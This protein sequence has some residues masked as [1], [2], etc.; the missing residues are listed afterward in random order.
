VKCALLGKD[1]SAERLGHV[2]DFLIAHGEEKEG[3]RRDAVLKVVK[4]A[5][6]GHGPARLLVLWDDKSRVAGTC[7]FNVCH[8]LTGPYV[9]VTELDVEP[10]GEIAALARQ[11]VAWT[12]EQG[13]AYIASAVDPAD[14]AM[15]KAAKSQG[16]E[17]RPAFWLELHVQDDG[18]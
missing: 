6:A 17:E 14:A 4:D 3:A 9:W 18:E 15:R 11:L 7:L 13:Y 16:M 10:P 1:A 5:A 12:R 8:G 2:A